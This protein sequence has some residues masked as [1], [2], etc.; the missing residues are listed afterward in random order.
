[1]MIELLKFNSM[2]KNNN[3]LNNSRNVTKS[4]QFIFLDL[5]MCRS[6]IRLHVTIQRNRKCKLHNG[7]IKPRLS[8]HH[9]SCCCM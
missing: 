5:G 7:K 8:H 9:I 2:K 6:L 4:K 1:M 3:L